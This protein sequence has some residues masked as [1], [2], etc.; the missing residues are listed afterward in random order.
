M[1]HRWWLALE[2]CVLFNLIRLFRIRGQSE[3]VARGFALGFMVNFFP[4]F[5]FGVVI[6]AALAR[7]S[8]GNLVAGFVGGATMTF[9]WPLLFYFNLRTGG[10]CIRPP[11]VVDELDDVTEKTMDALVW[12]QTFTLG[13]VTIFADGF[14][15][16][17]F[18][19][20]SA[21]VPWVGY[22]L[23]ELIRRVEP[24]AM[25]SWQ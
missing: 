1:L 10:L 18:T 15:T 25:W 13:A 11:V 6:S 24:T 17:D 16:G 12:G 22:P 5:G 23:A 9:F 19:A 14:E 21:V 3:R 4:T 2:R 7:V 20:W 8:G